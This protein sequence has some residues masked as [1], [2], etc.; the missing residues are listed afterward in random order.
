MNERHETFLSAVD[1]Y[2][3]AV[4][5]QPMNAHTFAQEPLS[6]DGDYTA[7]ATAD[8]CKAQVRHHST[9]V[10]SF[11]GETAWSDAVREAEDLNMAP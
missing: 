1:C 4:Y 3:D 8:G 9:V 11:S 2:E 6:F 5:H 7:W 10:R